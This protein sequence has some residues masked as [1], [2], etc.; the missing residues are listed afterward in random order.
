MQPLILNV[1][2]SGT[3]QA[4]LMIDIIQS[5]VIALQVVWSRV[6]DGDS[7]SAG[8]LAIDPAFEIIYLAME[9]QFFFLFGVQ[10]SS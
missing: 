9:F 10:Y 6:G 1:R 4:N 2:L 5:F 3:P 8:L 7:L